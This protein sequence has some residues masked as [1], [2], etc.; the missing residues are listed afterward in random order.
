MKELG[1][2]LIGL[3]LAGLIGCIGYG[4]DTH[5]IWW[6]FSTLLVGI[7]YGLSLVDY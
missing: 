1:L 4:T 7:G 6:T 3:G 2:T 5:M